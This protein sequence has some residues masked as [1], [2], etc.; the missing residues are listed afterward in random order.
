MRMGRR[1][2]VIGIAASAWPYYARSEPKRVPLIGV[3]MAHLESDAQAQVHLSAFY[4]GLQELGWVDGVN[5]RID[6]RWTVADPERTHDYAAELVKQDPD[7]ILVVTPPALAEMQQATQSVPIVFV[8]VADPV[9][10]GFVKT[11]ARPEGNI[12]GFTSFE[13]TMSVKWL[14]LL[15]QISP[16]ISRLA[17]I[18][19]PTTTSAS[20]YILGP[21]GAAAQSFGIQLITADASDG[22]GIERAFDLF[23]RKSANGLIAMPDA[24]FTVNRERLIALAA[25][26]RIPAIYYYRYFATSGGLMTYG[27]NT[28]DFFRRAA[29]YVD[30]ILRGK[31]PGELPVQQPSK[32]EFVIN[33]GTARALGLDVPQSLLVRADEVLE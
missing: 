16:R 20:S 21:L 31:K 17:V 23:V 11:L 7:V 19:N 9:A 13:E 15:R 28:V 6:H 27:P 1:E 30:R 25:R 8:M 29:S 33:L 3:L 26:S 5:V 12:T 18:R 14:E 4:Q 24:V 22:D 32:F 2:F 10:A